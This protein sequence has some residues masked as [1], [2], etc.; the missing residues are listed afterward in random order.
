MGVV[1][2]KCQTPNIFFALFGS[3]EFHY[4]SVALQGVDVL[5]KT[6]AKIVWPVPAPCK[7]MSGDLSDWRLFGG[8][9]PAIVA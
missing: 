8:R 6:D 4:F 5:P 7:G 3:N 9:A 1:N 2:D